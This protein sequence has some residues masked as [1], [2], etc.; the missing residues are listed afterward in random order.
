M[1]TPLIGRTWIEPG[2]GGFSGKKSSIGCRPILRRKAILGAGLF[3]RITGGR[4]RNMQEDKQ[5]ERGKCKRRRNMARRQV[6]LTMI[7]LG[8]LT[9]IVTTIS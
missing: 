1:S 9:K 5:H 7:G 8:F 6:G 3:W 2:H 4:K